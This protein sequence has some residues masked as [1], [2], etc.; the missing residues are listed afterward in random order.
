MVQI[1]SNLSRNDLEDLMQT[2]KTSVS[3]GPKVGD[4]ARLYQ[5]VGL[6][7]NSPESIHYQDLGEGRGLYVV[8]NNTIISPNRLYL[9]G[10]RWKHYDTEEAALMDGKKLAR[11]MSHKWAILNLMLSLMALEEKA[12]MA[13]VN[14][15][16]IG[17]GKAV[18]F[19]RQY[20]AKNFSSNSEDL[21]ELE[22]RVLDR[23]GPVLDLLG[24]Y[25]FAPDMGTN[26]R[27]VDYVSKFCPNTV[28]CVSRE[29]GGS[30]DPS[31]I[32]AR[33]VYESM[34]EAVKH[35]LGKDSLEGLTIALQGVG[36]VGK[37]LVEY[38][39]ENKDVRLIITDE[40][41]SAASAVVRS[42]LDRG[43]NATY[44]V[45]HDIYS[46]KCDIF[47]PNA[48][49]QILTPKNI[50]LIARANDEHGVMI[51]GGANNQIDD[52]HSGTREQVEAMFKQYGMLYAPDFVVNLGGILNLMYEFPNVKKELRGKYIQ[53][54][55]LVRVRGV[56]DILSRI[57][58]LSQQRN[59]C[60]TQALAERLAEEHI[61]RYALRDRY[62]AS[63]LLQ[64]AYL[65]V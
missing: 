35:R 16:R 53:N 6:V 57:F 55:P 4:K 58:E 42:L 7:L 15:S 30:G 17:G 61:A 49:G 44:V 25:I 37:N 33:G 40:K 3:F 64:R 45:A 28:A 2:G 23:I 52:R 8:R 12:T 34:L 11:G 56:R 21:N 19:D 46:Q 32:T 60:S 47:S 54:V 62:D 5:I 39:A 65:E 29:I 18:I 38:I 14:A 1:T 41:E 24:Q 9:G 63:G 27:Y 22:M 43:V 26:S 51:V 20:D 13:E 31:V 48:V 50:E 59:E 36:K 10:T